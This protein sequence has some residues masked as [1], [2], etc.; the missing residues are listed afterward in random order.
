MKYYFIVC[1]NLDKDTS[2][3]DDS[4]T[5]DGHVALC[6]D[7]GGTA[8]DGIAMYTDYDKALK[9]YKETWLPW[10]TSTYIYLLIEVDESEI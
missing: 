9:T 8:K 7:S 4:D 10:A 6:K 5:A 2:S 1:E 3:W